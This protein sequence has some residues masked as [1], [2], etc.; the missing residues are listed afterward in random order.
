MIISTPNIVKMPELNGQI[1][2]AAILKA[3]TSTLLLHFNPGQC[4][5]GK[6]WLARQLELLGLEMLVS[7]VAKTCKTIGMNVLLNDPPR[8]RIEG[9][10]QFVSLETIQKEADIITLHVPLKMDGLIQHFILLMK[11]FCK[12][13]QKSLY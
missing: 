9:S 8:E 1:L 7:R 4:A 13:L 6:I 10:E 2:Q 11:N 5:N 3:L 12:I